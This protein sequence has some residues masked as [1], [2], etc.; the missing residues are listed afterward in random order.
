MYYISRCVLGKGFVGNDGRRYYVTSVPTAASIVKLPQ[1]AGIG[2]SPVNEYFPSPPTV[3]LPSSDRFGL[4]RWGFLSVPRR[5]PLA[6]TW[7]RPSPSSAGKYCNLS[8][9]RL[10]LQF[11]LSWPALQPVQFLRHQ[12]SSEVLPLILDARI[13]GTET[14]ALGLNVDRHLPLL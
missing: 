5:L 7:K 4:R 3:S 8:R 6:V 10:V 13:K 11:F 2:G 9:F 12:G 1:A 14:C